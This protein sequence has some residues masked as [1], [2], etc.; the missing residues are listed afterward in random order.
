VHTQGFALR[1][2]RSKNFHGFITTHI[3]HGGANYGSDTA[4]GA[5]Y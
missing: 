4:G 3:S 1:F 5:Y 2:R